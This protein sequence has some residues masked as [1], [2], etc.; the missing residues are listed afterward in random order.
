[1]LKCNLGVFLSLAIALGHMHG[2]QASAQ[3]PAFLPWQSWKEGDAWQVKIDLYSREWMEEI[4]PTAPAKKKAMAVSTKRLEIKIAP[5]EMIDGATCRQLVFR[6]AQRNVDEKNALFRLYIRQRDGVPVKVMQ[7]DED[8][9]ITHL[10]SWD[11]VPFVTGVPEGMPIEFL[12]FQERKPPLNGRPGRSFESRKLPTGRNALLL[13]SLLRF[14][15]QPKLRIV[16][17]WP[18]NGTWWEYYERHIQGH[19]DLVAR[20]VTASPLPGSKPAPPVITLTSPKSPKD[21][22]TGL[23]ADPR[24]QAKLTANLSQP[25]LSVIFR[26]LETASGLIFSA[27]EG[28]DVHNPVLGSTVWNNTPAYAAMDQVAR[29]DNVRGNW[30]KTADGYCLHSKLLAGGATSSD[31]RAWLLIAVLVGFLVVCGL[32]LL[33]MWLR[34]AGATGRALHPP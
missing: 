13:D 9:S 7:G 29:A 31:S 3:G 25:P 2:S 32:H 21:D 11:A 18:E 28:I 12:P 10:E 8:V 15:H 17:I 19:K 20:T 14:G 16:Q 22:P 30:E 24:L 27:E 34:R 23:S 33:R 5:D 1:M 26:Q 4:G 6:P